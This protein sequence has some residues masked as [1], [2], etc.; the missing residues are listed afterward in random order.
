MRGFSGLEVSQARICP[1]K[2]CLIPVFLKLVLK[3]SFGFLLFQT[4]HFLFY[5]VPHK[6]IARPLAHI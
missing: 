6:V 2:L 3:H 1:L 5:F 4:E